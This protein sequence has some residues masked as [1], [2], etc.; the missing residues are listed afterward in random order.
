MGNVDEKHFIELNEKYGDGIA[1]NQYNNEYSI[2]QAR[3]SQDGDIWMEWCHPAKK[4]GP[5]EKKFPLK[6]SLG[7]K[8]QAVQILEKIIYMIEGR[9]EP[10]QDSKVDDS[11]IPF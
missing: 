4:D 5:G 11:S 10:R 2:V 8:E 9:S 7:M 6:V 3:K 1:L